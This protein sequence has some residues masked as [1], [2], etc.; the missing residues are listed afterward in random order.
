MTEF[1]DHRSLG[2]GMGKKRV[3][4]VGLVTAM[5]HS[6]TFNIAVMRAWAALASFRKAA[7]PAAL[8]AA[9]QSWGHA[10]SLAH[11]L[12]HGLAQTDLPA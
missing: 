11:G 1:E 7:A 9:V 6:L 4:L 10:H 5:G 8:A 3:E 2:P 12:A